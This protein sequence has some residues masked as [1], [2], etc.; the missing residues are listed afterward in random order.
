MFCSPFLLSSGAHS[1]AQENTQKPANTVV[2]PTIH[3]R[4]LRNPG[5]GLILYVHGKWVT[6]RQLPLPPEVDILYPTVVWHD[7][8]KTPGQYNWQ[9]CESLVTALKLAEKYDLKVAIRLVTSYQD[10]ESPIPEY[11]L[12]K[13]VKL[14]PQERVRRERYGYKCFFEPEWWNPE[15]ILAY[16]NLVKAYAKEFDGHPRVDWIDMRYYGFWG[17]GHRWNTTEPWPAHVDKREYCKHWID[18]F[19]HAFKKTRLTVETVP[20]ENVPYP[21]GTAVDYAV[22]KGAWMRRDGFGCIGDED[23]RFLKANWQTSAVI[24]E[25][26]ASFREF[27]DLK[28]RKEWIPGS[29]PVSIDGLFDE[30]FEYHVNYASFGFSYEDY[31]ALKTKRPDLL[32][33]FSLKTGYRMIVT[34]GA[35]RRN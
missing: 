24:A 18:A 11:L 16:E 1:F 19:V 26:V 30:M 7:I 31:A 8:E 25:P 12:K 5:M 20:D 17:E 34:E 33:K 2:H 9:A 14:F 27:F 3:E 6:P 35:G 32:K 10:Y 23:S 13:G 22:E 21:K 28:V 4:H 15:Y 29:Q